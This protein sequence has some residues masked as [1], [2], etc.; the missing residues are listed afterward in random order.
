MRAGWA[1]PAALLMFAGSLCS[2]LALGQEARN[3]AAGTTSSV[4]GTPARH[5]D[6]A[7]PAISSQDDT[8][9][10]LEGQRRFAANCGRCHQAPHKYPPRMMATIVR[11]MR[12]RATITDEDMRYILRYMTQ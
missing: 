4:A 11:H 12:V 2:S 10:R 9:W 8:R 1:L 3:L 6:A 7:P 5:P